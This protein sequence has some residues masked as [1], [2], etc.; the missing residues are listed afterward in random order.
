[1]L[2]F[3]EKYQI[4]LK[5]I[6]NLNIYELNIY[7]SIKKF[8]ELN[9]KISEK[10]EDLLYNIL[11]R[12]ILLTVKTKTVYMYNENFYRLDYHGDYLL[13]D[14]PLLRETEMSS[15]ELSEQITNKIAMQYNTSGLTDKY[16][17]VKTIEI[18]E[19]IK[20]LREFLT[21][22]NDY[23]TLLKKFKNARKNTSRNKYI[24]ALKSIITEEYN[25]N[26]IKDTI[27]FKHWECK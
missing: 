5:E 25:Y 2:S 12:E 18:P 17:F 26:L 14:L 20:N 7:N 27:K 6:D 10:Q 22:Y 21:F 24:K 13:D 1:M 9:D 8:Y 16:K 11:K 15:E 23:E 3:R 4:T 19:S